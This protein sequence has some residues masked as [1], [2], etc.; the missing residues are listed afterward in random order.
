METQVREVLRRVLVDDDFLDEMLSDPDRA[1][2]DYDLTDEERSVLANRNRDVL[3]LMRLSGEGAEGRLLIITLELDLTLWPFLFINVDITL[4][5]TE[6]GVAAR[7]RRVNQQRVA[8]LAASVR[9]ARA[10]ADRLER[11]QEMLEVLSG[12]TELTS[13]SSSEPRSEP[14]QHEP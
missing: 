13:R 3:D 2:R 7:E 8:S 4:D 10:G 5:F 12:A 9:A 14:E 11:I 6:S 1:L